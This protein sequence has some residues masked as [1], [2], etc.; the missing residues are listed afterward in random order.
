MTSKEVWTGKKADDNNGCFTAPSKKGGRSNEAHIGC[1]ESELHNG[2]M[3]LFL[4]FRP[5]NSS[6][7]HSEIH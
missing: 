2:Y 5:N 6:D 1:A 3:I 4:G 7:Y